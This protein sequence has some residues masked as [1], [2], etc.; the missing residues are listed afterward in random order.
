MELYEVKSF[1]EEKIEAKIGAKIGVFQETVKTFKIPQFSFRKPKLVVNISSYCKIEPS[2][3]VYV[4]FK[5]N[6]T[7]IWLENDISPQTWFYFT[8]PRCFKS[9]NVVAWNVSPLTNIFGLLWSF[10]SS[11]TI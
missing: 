11:T 4:I 5:P 10:P 1:D 8:I 6:R 2:L 7:A 3:R 9:N